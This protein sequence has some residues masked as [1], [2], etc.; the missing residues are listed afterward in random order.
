MPARISKHNIRGT[1]ASSKILDIWRCDCNGSL[2]N[3]EPFCEP[4]VESSSI[5]N[6]V[7]KIFCRPVSAI[8]EEKARPLA[9]KPRT[10]V[11]CCIVLHAQAHAHAR[12]SSMWL[13]LGSTHICWG[14]V[15]YETFIWTSSLTVM[16]PQKRIVKD[17]WR[18][19]GLAAVAS[20]LHVG[21]T[22]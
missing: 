4:I 7:D 1:L 14:S 5:P 8:L 12:H 16:S 11:Q 10:G 3:N 9:P 20:F 18:K 2:Q 17:V 6:H 19:Q 15:W 22:C 13:R 21:K